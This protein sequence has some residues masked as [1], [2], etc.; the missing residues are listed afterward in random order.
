MTVKTR[1]AEAV[2]LQLEIERVSQHLE[3][4]AASCSRPQALP[5]LR[6]HT[7]VAKLEIERVS[8]HLEQVAA[9]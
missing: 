4:V 2:T 6:P 9:S 7:L 5:A 3:Q 8:Q 1:N